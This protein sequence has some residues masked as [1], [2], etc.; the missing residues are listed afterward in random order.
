MTTY[1]K[2][3]PSTEPLTLP[4]SKP[5]DLKVTCTSDVYSATNYIIIVTIIMIMN[6]NMIIFIIAANCCWHL[7]TLCYLSGDAAAC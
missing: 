2:S 3:K 4:Y 5:L 6:M 1:N 7:E